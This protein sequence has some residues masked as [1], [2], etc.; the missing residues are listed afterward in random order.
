[1]KAVLMFLIDQFPDLLDLNLTVSIVILFILCVRQFLKR[2]PKIFSYALWGIVLLRLLV[3]VSIESPMSFVPERTEFSSMVEV[4]EVLPEIQF[5]TPRDRADNEWHAE[6]APSGEPLVQTY[7]TADAQTYLTL[8]WLVGMAG[9][10]A[11][12][13][14]SYIKLRQKLRTAI[15]FRNRILIADHIDSPFVMGLFRPVIYLPG[16]LSDMERRY[17]IAHER[18]HIRRGD[19]VFKALGFLALTIHWFNPLV[20]LAFSLANRDMEMSCDEAVIRKLGTDVRAAYSETLLNL[21]TGQR[22]F[23][24][25]PLAFGEGNPAGRVRNL[26]KWKKPAVWTIVVCAVLCVA[27]AA[28]LLTD[29]MQRRN[30]LT[31]APEAEQTNSWG[32]SIVPEYVSSTGAAAIFACS[33]DITE[34]E[35]TYGDF[36]S[37][38]RFEDGAWKPV[39]ELPG[40]EYTVG[41]A[42]Y[43][44]A[45]GYG[46]VHE[47]QNRFGQLPDG[48]YR[49]GKVVRLEQGDGTA[50]EQ[51][52][53][54]YF[55]IPD[56][57]R[58]GYIPLEDLPEIYSAEQAMLDGCFVMTDGVAREN[59]E[60]FKQFVICCWNGIP[61][62]IRTVNWHY[63]EDSHWSVYDLSFDGNGY[64]LTTPENTYT[65]RYLKQFTGEKAWE[66]ADHDAFDYYILVN[67]DSVT[68]EDI[69]SGKLD[70][71]DWQNPAHWTVYAD[72]IYRP[73]QPQLPVNLQKAVLEF[74]GKELVSTTDFDRLE[75][76][77][78]LFSNAEF[79]G[80]E[81]KT[82]SVG[83]GL[84]LILY[85]QSGETVTIELDPDDD[86][87]RIQGEFVW[88]GAPDEP[89]Y[90]E[91]LWYYLEIEKWPDAVYD[92]CPNAYEIHSV[93]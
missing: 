57:I 56:S 81:S 51:R 4:N 28:C 43:P 50:Q 54:G 37:L 45:A 34:L 92:R 22:L 2:A 53:Y 5:E 90:I 83:V 62:M 9:M 69:M 75:K 16:A 26:A 44:V 18:H 48:Y 72:L 36:F 31:D 35:L 66:G 85:T 78:L 1:M 89:S 33:E 93:G 61:G 58:S 71:N 32:I 47:W 27:L 15:P 55:G 79:L 87:C 73:K 88:Y 38:E 19:H 3:P 23:S 70:M 59:K 24:V 74:K 64:T 52:V 91:K 41:D 21:A 65:F 20:W 49:I 80:F 7:H 25:T 30:E 68:F 14:V 60:L 86:L 42:V 63:G 10:A 46:M 40:F 29:P 82:H 11:Y 67:D 39:E 6:N 8:I 84:N 17:I 13:A 12:S 77:W 76:I